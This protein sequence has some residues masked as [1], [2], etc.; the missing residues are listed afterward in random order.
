MLGELKS[1]FFLVKIS[2]LL[3]IFPKQTQLRGCRMAGALKLKCQGSIE[4][5]NGKT[6]KAFILLYSVYY[7][8]L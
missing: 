1:K 3:S 2:S 5:V 6:E 8:M 4:W 7:I